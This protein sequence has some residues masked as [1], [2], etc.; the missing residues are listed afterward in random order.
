MYSWIICICFYFKNRFEISFHMIT[1]LKNGFKGIKLQNG[2][3][4]NI[5]YVH[6]YFILVQFAFKRDQSQWHNDKI[7][8]S[9]IY[10]WQPRVVYDVIRVSHHKHNWSTFVVCCLATTWNMVQKAYTTHFLSVFML[11]SMKIS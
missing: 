11:G 10:K 1:I 4:L 7:E 3:R 6:F 2:C 9:L 8:E 5:L